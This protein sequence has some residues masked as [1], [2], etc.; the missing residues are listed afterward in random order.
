MAHWLIKVYGDDDYEDGAEFKLPSNL[1]DVEIAV[2][3]QRL[4]C[5]RLAVEEV[6][7]ASRRSND[8]KRTNHLD[9]IGRGNPIH[10]GESPYYT[11]EFI[12]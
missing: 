1:K 8:P 9:R 4:A 10:F 3:V 12:S 6:L 11:A 2:I 5:R 7:S